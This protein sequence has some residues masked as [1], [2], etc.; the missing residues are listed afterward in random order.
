MYQ[1]LHLFDFIDIPLECVKFPVP[2]VGV[3][4]SVSNAEVAKGDV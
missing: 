1:L 2:P 3:K 4:D